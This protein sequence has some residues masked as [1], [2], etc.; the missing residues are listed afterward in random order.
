MASSLHSRVYD[1][2]SSFLAQFALFFWTKSVRGLHIICTEIKECREGVCGSPW[3]R[4]ARFA[5]EQSSSRDC[6]HSLPRISR[7]ITCAHFVNEDACT[8]TML[9]KTLTYYVNYVHR[10]DIETTCKR[11]NKSKLIREYVCIHSS[12]DK[13]L[14]RD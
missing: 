14:F 5:R 8:R 11:M 10:D 6:R 3:R 7:R 12:S 2:H 9:T 1:V 13:N 4:V